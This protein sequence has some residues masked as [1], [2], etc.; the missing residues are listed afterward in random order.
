MQ[1]EFIFRLSPSNKWQN[2]GVQDGGP[3]KNAEMIS[4]DYQRR[5]MVPC[6]PFLVPPFLILVTFFAERSLSQNQLANQ[7]ASRVEPAHLGRCPCGPQISVA[8]LFLSM[9]WKS[10]CT[11][12]AEL[13]ST[14]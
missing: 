5:L 3:T 13:N 10:A 2:V 4:G 8:M 1:T 14:V 7:T 6:N 12:I 9:S 11:T